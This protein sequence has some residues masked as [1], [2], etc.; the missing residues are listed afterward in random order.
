MKRLLILAAA[1]TAA[2]TV[3]PAAACP[4]PPP[5]WVPPTEEQRLESF[6]GLATDIVYGVITHSA[7]PGE[8]ARFRVYHVYR[9]G[10]RVG[11]TIDLPVNWDHPVPICSGMMAPPPAKPV[12]FY[13]VAALSEDRRSLVFIKPEHVQAMIAKGWIKSAR[14]R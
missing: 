1:A 8:P 6:V 14:A 9:G 2:L 3:Q 12:G 11:D 5:G 13:G 7:G 10:Q 4:P